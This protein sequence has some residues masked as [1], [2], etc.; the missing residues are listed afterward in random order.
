MRDHLGPDHIH[1]DVEEATAEMLPTLDEGR[2][3]TAAPHA[4]LAA[5]RSVVVLGRYPGQESHR[6][7]H[8][9]GTAPQSSRWVWLEVTIYPR[10][11]TGC[12]RAIS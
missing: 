8:M 6:I 3:E 12:E 9:S 4:A 5:F 1:L 10:T 7:G 2:M 11:E